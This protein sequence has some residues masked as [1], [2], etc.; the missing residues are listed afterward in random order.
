[1]IGS[2]KGE[3]N[4]EGTDSSD[5]EIVDVIS[6]DYDRGKRRSTPLDGYQSDSEL[7]LMADDI[8]SDVI[9]VEGVGG[10]EGVVITERHRH[11][12]SP[13]TILTSETPPTII[14]ARESTSDE[15]P[16]PSEK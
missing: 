12:S 14:T 3:K 8:V 16:K 9:G 15:H 10:V 1:M 13:P 4:K 5:L 7:S 11:W 6:S 2:K